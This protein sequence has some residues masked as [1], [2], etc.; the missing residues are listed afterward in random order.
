MKYLFLF[1]F[2]A[3]CADTDRACV[4][5]AMTTYDSPGKK[6]PALTYEQAIETCGVKKK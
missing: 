6:T 2:L 3:G 5:T 1:L 4:Q